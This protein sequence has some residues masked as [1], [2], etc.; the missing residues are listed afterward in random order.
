MIFI[1]LFKPLIL[2]CI[3]YQSLLLITLSPQ[4]VAFAWGKGTGRS[5]VGCLVGLAG[6]VDD[7]TAS[8]LSSLPNPLS[9]D[10]LNR[11]WPICTPQV[12]LLRK[13]STAAVQV[14]CGT[15]ILS[16][17]SRHSLSLYS[18]PLSP[19]PRQQGPRVFASAS[20]VGHAGSE[21]KPNDD[22]LHSR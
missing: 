22:H 5:S 19:T 13:P 7:R 21:P 4:V 14:C 2:W 16:C 6:R 3:W 9:L 12:P 11:A 10:C 15:V 20:P 1:L 8:P 17:P 18:L